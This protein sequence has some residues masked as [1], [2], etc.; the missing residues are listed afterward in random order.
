MY[1]FISKPVLT[2][3]SGNVSLVK[4]SMQTK[5]LDY[6]FI[7]YPAVFFRALNTIYYNTLMIILDNTIKVSKPQHAAKT[8]PILFHH[9]ILAPQDANKRS[10]I[11]HE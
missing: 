1:Q 6:I 5:S 8:L 4:F 2:L 7:E 11:C 9:Y 3:F 10:S